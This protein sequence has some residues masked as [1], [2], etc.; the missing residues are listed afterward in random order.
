MTSRRKNLSDRIARAENL[1]I[2]GRAPKIAGR[3]I[4]ENH[5]PKL[6]D[7]PVIRGQILFVRT[8]LGQFNKYDSE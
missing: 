2:V 1:E 6:I 3:E 8:F 7:T 4:R 5:P